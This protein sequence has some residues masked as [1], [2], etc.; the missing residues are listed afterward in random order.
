MIHKGQVGDGVKSVKGG[1][2]GKGRTSASGE[3]VIDK[4]LGGLNDE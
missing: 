4:Y 2:A 1:K 3:D